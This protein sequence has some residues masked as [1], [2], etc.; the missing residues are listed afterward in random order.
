VD[1]DGRDLGLA[2][3]DAEL[4]AGGHSLAVT[5]P[6]FLTYR[7][8]VLVIAGQT[9]EVAITQD[10]L[11]KKL[12]RKWWFWALTGVAAAGVATAIAVPVALSGTQSPLQ[13]T[14]PSGAARVN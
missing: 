11:Q 8:E 6:G 4:Q 10:L 1:V 9:R 7:N 3:L 12:Y 5:A 2:P 14:L 13:G